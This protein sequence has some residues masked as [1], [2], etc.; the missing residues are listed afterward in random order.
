MNTA[1]LAPERLLSSKCPD[2]N[3]LRRKPTGEMLMPLLT[4]QREPVDQT[5]HLAATTHTAAAR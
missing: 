4:R 1:T 5:S 2:R 3:D